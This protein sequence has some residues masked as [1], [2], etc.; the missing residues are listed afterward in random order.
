MANFSNNVVNLFAPK[1]RV[2]TSNFGSGGIGGGSS[3]AALQ[4]AVH[5]SQPKKT[6]PPLAVDFSSAFSNAYYSKNL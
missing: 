4:A 2:K 5:R 3:N 1:Q 6:S